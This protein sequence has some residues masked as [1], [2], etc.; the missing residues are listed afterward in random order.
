MV[1]IV[2]LSKKFDNRVLFHDFNLSI[3][4][5]EFVIILGKS[6]CGKTTLLNMIGGIEKVSGGKITV[7]DYEVTNPRSKEEYYSRIVGFLFQNYGL[8]E[9]K[10]VVQNLTIIPKRNRTSNSVD[11]VLSFVG[12]LDKKNDKV[13]RLS[14]GEQQRVALAR[15]IYKKCEL[16]LADEPTGSLDRDNAN[17]VMQLLHKLNGQGKTIIMVTHDESL[18]ENGDRVIRL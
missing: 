9:E 18:I 7:G 2:Q 8:I 10:T 5:G 6:G 16:I 11:E 14:G 15:L 3:Q 4:D 13:Y 12:M 1:E 17:K